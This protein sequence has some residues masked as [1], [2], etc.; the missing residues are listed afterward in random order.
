M[1]N[2]KMAALGRKRSCIRELFEYGIQQA[3][4][5]GKE[6]V[7]DYSIGNPSIPSPPVVNETFAAVVQSMDSLSVHGYTPAAGLPEARAAIAQDLN[8]RYKASLHMNNIFFTCGAAPALVSVIRALATEQSEFVCIAPYFPEYR[9]FVEMNGATFVAVSPDTEHFQINL[10]ALE[11][12]IGIHTQALIL[13]CP[14]NPSGV[15]YST[16]TLRNLSA[17]LKQKSETIGHPIYLISDEPYRELIYDGHK[18]P[19]LPNFYSNTIICYSFSKSLSLPGERIGY[20][21]VPDSVEDCKTVFDAIAG[22][23]RVSGHVCA[24]SLQQRVVARCIN[25]RP[26]IQAYKINRDLLYSSLTKMGYECVKPSGAFYMFVKAPCGSSKLFSD[27]AK[28]KNLLV[29]PG[30]DFGCPSHFRISTCVS[31]QMIERSL[32]IFE[33]LIKTKLLKRNLP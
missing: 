33:E 15:V 23:A 22:A 32:P 26:D 7:F 9:P 13:N 10:E 2:D 6:N 11:S 29:V 12:Q 30:D 4:V 27:C 18:A 21:C 8:D 25:S 28:E 31:P 1:V 20:I 19:F 14:N 17:I 3:S 16:E 24:P 5:V